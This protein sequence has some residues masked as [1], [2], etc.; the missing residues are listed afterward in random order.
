MA[1]WQSC[2]DTRRIWDKGGK[3]TKGPK[4]TVGMV[5]YC[6]TGVGGVVTGSIV[7]RKGEA[8]RGCPTALSD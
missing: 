4:S 6:N 5:T 3:I 1:V 8:V 7:S 2:V